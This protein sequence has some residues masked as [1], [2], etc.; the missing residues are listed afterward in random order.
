MSLTIRSIS[1][2]R[3]LLEY[4]LSRS[5]PP[6]LMVTIASSLLELIAEHVADRRGVGR[7][8]LHAHA[9]PARRE[10]AAGELRPARIVVADEQRRSA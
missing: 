1:D 9:R 2:C 8:R 5:F 6:T 7:Q 10:V 3:G 4:A